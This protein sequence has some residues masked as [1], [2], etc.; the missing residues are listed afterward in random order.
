MKILLIGDTS[1]RGNWGCRATSFQLRALLEQYGKITGAVD[2]AFLSDPVGPRTN[3]KRRW[4]LEGG[5]PRSTLLNPVRSIARKAFLAFDAS[6]LQKHQTIIEKVTPNDFPALARKI[7]E[8]KLFPSIAESMADAD[9]VVVNG[10][11]S[12]MQDRGVARFK[13]LLAYTAKS[14]FKKPVAIVNHTADLRNPKLAEFGRLVY[15]LLDDAL[16]REPHSVE[17]GREFR[18]NAAFAAD[19]AFRFTPLDAETFMR[20]AGRGDYYST[21]PEDASAFDASIPYI[22]VGGSSAYLNKEAQFPQLAA[23]YEALCARLSKIAPVVVTASSRP[24]DKLLRPVAQRLGLPFLGLSTPV[25]Q[26]V[27]VLG[28]A[29]AY[30][31]G[32]W[33]P[34]IL[35]LTGGTP[36]VSFSANSDFK[37]RGVMDLAGIEQTPLSAFEIGGNLERIISRTMDLIDEGSALRSRLQVRSDE[38]RRSSTDNARMLADLAGVRNAA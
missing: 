19:C 4:A 12:F 36:L 20:V 11:G 34:A 17:M 32:R 30:V 37:S 1:N 13:F 7:F 27:D 26:S 14:F 10:E 29:L 25:Q 18:S 38:L 23:D 22:A 33:H 6:A 21:Y 16:F 28:N 3:F 31:G 9:A 5:K 2:T 24:D 35:A 8:R 15:P